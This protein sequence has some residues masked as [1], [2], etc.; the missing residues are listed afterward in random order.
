[1]FSIDLEAEPSWV[2]GGSSLRHHESGNKDGRLGRV[3]EKTE[4]SSFLIARCLLRG[5]NWKHSLL[6]VFCH[7]E[8]IGV[9]YVKNFKPCY[10]MACAGHVLLA[11]EI[12]EE[13]VFSPSDF[14]LKPSLQCLPVLILCA[15]PLLG[16]KHKRTRNL[17]SK[18]PAAIA[19]ILIKSGCKSLQ[20]L[21]LE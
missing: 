17:K 21:T 7:L 5:P 8:D 6:K 19:L 20:R 2:N 1:M 18:D 14:C 3:E 12:M 16:H 11:P 9:K 15:T 10:E 4:R 13:V